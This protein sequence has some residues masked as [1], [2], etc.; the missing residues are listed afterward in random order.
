MKFEK[1]KPGMVLLDIHSY[2]MGNT[3]M[4]QLGLW[5]VMVVS[6]DA[7][8]P[9]PSLPGQA[10]RQARQ[11]VPRSGGAQD[12]RVASRQQHPGQRVLRP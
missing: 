11:G 2:R 5:E 6:V 1:I 12:A 9:E 7:A 4:R 3:T 10:R 8:H